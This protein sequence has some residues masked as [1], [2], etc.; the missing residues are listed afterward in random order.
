MAPSQRDQNEDKR[1]EQCAN[2][3]SVYNRRPYHPSAIN[4]TPPA[5]QRITQEW[6]LWQEQRLTPG[7]AT[8][9]WPLPPATV[10]RARFN[11]TSILVVVPRAC[12][13]GLP[14]ALSTSRGLQG[15]PSQNALSTAACCLTP[16]R[17]SPFG[18]Q[19]R[20]VKTTSPPFS[21]DR[22]TASPP[23]PCRHTNCSVLLLRNTCAIP[24]APDGTAMLVHSVAGLPP[25]KK[26]AA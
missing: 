7:C 24:C 13:H 14:P 25:S 26:H 9:A 3:N 17:S 18:P 23:W 5:R 11:W 2:H 19:S 22:A 1:S 15:P 10:P 21:R 8:E 6:E 12:P 4:G 20:A 16:R